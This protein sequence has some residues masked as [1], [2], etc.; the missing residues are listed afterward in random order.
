VEIPHHREPHQL[1][2][3]DAKERET[4]RVSAIAEP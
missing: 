1:H 4:E 2:L 3:F